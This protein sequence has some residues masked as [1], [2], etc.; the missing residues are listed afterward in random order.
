MYGSAENQADHDKRAIMIN[1]QILKG[2]IP[3]NHSDSKKNYSFQLVACLN[4]DSSGKGYMN[5]LFVKF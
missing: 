1:R 5:Y 4:L 3:T 2:D